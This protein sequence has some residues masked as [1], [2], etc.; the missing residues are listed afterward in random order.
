MLP[1]LYQR[2]QDRNY[3]DSY[4]SFMPFDR[5]L[6]S[7]KWNKEVLDCTYA[8][9]S[10]AD[11]ALA[12]PPS[13]WISGSYWYQTPMLFKEL[14]QE[15]CQNFICQ[16]QSDWDKANYKLVNE[17]LNTE[18]SLYFVPGRNPPYDALY[19]ATIFIYSQHKRFAAVVR[20][21]D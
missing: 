20:F 12:E 6:E 16:C 21:G 10:L 17:A 1:I 7:R 9:V 13:T 2:Y 5:V 11:K 15:G 18:G 4:F 19:Q 14:K 8:I 3:A